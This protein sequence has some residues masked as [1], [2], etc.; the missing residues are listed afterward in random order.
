MKSCGHF[1]NKVIKAVILRG[2]MQ[3][4]AGS[5][6]ELKWQATTCSTSYWFSVLNLRCVLEVGLDKHEYVD[7]DFP[8]VRVTHIF[9]PNPE[10]CCNYFSQQN[11]YFISST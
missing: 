1:S 8:R 11:F 3:G 5:T 6:G 9:T 4:R 10:D 2:V 7:T